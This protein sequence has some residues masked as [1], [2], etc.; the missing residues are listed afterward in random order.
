M[1]RV[2]LVSAVAPHEEAAAG[3]DCIT[4]ESV[5]TL[6]V[7]EEEHNRVRCAG[8]DLTGCWRVNH[9]LRRSS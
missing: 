6:K 7:V 4:Y 2:D 5:A 8:D 3:P 9:T 1:A